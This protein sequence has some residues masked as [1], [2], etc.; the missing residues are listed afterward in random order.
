MQEFELA[1]KVLH[2]ANRI[3][4]NRNNHLKELGLTAGQADSL[5]FFDK[6]EDVTINHLK[7]Y[8]QV[9]HQTA[10]GICTRLEEK[11]L[12]HMI[13]SEQDARAK[14]IVLTK[15]G[16]EMIS[17]L[18]NNGTHTGFELLKDMDEK[19]RA[20]FDLLIQKAMKNIP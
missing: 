20:Q 6:H 10:R 7:D 4:A 17:A 13:T 14:K 9:R 1:R 19:E 8:L 16:K 5:L 18:K 12:I 2:L 15:A 11:G 3:I